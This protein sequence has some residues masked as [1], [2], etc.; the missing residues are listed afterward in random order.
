[1]SSRYAYRAKSKCRSDLKTGR[2]DAF[3][4]HKKRS[5]KCH[6]VKHILSGILT[7][8]GNLDENHDMSIY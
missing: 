6:N 7:K 8:L 1:M 4:F 5:L 3:F 2:R